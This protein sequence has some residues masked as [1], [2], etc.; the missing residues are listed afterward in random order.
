MLTKRAVHST[1]M[2]T[3]WTLSRASPLPQGLGGVGRF[4]IW[5][6]LNV[7]VVLGNLRLAPSN[8][9]VGL[10]TK[11][12]VHSARM[13]TEWT[14]SRASPLAQGVGGV[15]RFCIWRPLNVGVVLGNLLLAPSNVGVGL[16]TKR[17]VHSAR[18][19]T[20]WTLSRASPLPQGVDD[21][22]RFSGWPR[23]HPR[24]GNHQAFAPSPRIGGWPPHIWPFA[25]DS[26]LA[27]AHDHE[28][29]VATGCLFY[30][31]S[32]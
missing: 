30:R 26:L 15:G 18:M 19:L 2:L 32:Y 6:P 4:C 23:S 13:L 22:E 9:G 16:L 25:P 11:R 12:A 21:V 7:G 27:V 24:A 28:S 10:L 1:M 20:E 8:V 3:E 29:P 14:L 31:S 5:R 17:A